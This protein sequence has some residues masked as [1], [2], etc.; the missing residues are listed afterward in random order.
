M[1]FFDDAPQEVIPVEPEPEMPPWFGPGPDVLP[2][3]LLTRVVLVD[4]ND[5]VIVLDHFQVFPTGLE[6]SLNL[7][8]RIGLNHRDIPWELTGPND[9]GSDPSFLRLGFSFSDGSKWTNAPEPMRTHDQEPAGPLLSNRGGGGGGRVWSMRQWLW[10]LPPAGDL[11]FYTAWPAF[12]VEE[13]SVVIDATPFTDAA[14]KCRRLWSD[15][16]AK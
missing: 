16:P 15:Q 8:L 7:M 6:F 13:T 1:S 14:A 3:P 10:P 11:T 4:N 5:A 12:G 2:T 9:A